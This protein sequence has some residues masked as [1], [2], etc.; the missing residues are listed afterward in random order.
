M[1]C[2]IMLLAAVPALAQH[3]IGNGG[4]G[5]VCPSANGHR[6]VIVADILYGGVAWG[7][8]PDLGP[9]DRSW[10]DKVEKAIRRIPSED[11]RR[12]REY[13]RAL[14]TFV[15]RVEFVP[16][17]QI[18]RTSD[19]LSE[20]PFMSDLIGQRDCEFVQLANLVFVAQPWNDYV[21]RI[22]RGLF[23]TLSNDQRAILVLHEIVYREW[24]QRGGG[25]LEPVYRL[26]AM[27]ASNHLAFK[28]FQTYRELL[29]SM[30][31]PVD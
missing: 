6:E 2:L 12:R 20:T 4:I 22:D 21:C 17:S 13:L 7:L 25:S 27:L 14:R 26:V 19:Y 30:G 31:W 3:G 16:S 15:A 10:R 9:V 1:A 23:Q 28:S 11:R 29:L 18:R 8:R 5:L 24:L